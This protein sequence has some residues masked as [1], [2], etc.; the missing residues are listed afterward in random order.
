MRLS[1]LM[2]SPGA[3]DETQV[4]SVPQ[5]EVALRVHDVDDSQSGTNSEHVRHDDSKTKPRSGNKLNRPSS[6]RHFWEHLATNEEVLRR[7][8]THAEYGLTSEVAC[9]RLQKHG[10]N[11]LTLTHLEPWW[12]HVVRHLTDPLLILVQVGVLLCFSAFIV[13]RTNRTYLYM[14]LFVLSIIAFTTMLHLAHGQWA[15][16]EMRELRLRALRTGRSVVVRDGR[17]PTPI[18]ARDLVVGDV[19]LLREG[20]IVPADVRILQSHNFAVNNASLTG[21]SESITLASDTASV[22]DPLRATNLAFRGTTALQGACSAVVI[23]TGDRTLLATTAS[24]TLFSTDTKD[25][26]AQS[27]LKDNLRDFCINVCAVAVF[28]GITFFIVNLRLLRVNSK[29][30]ITSTVGIVTSNVPVGVL[31]TVT[32]SLMVSAQILRRRHKAVVKK[33]HSIATLGTITTM[34]IDKTG[35]LT[36]NDM[37]VSHL[38]FGGNVHVVDAKWQPPPVSTVNES[39][40]DPDVSGRSIESETM[41]N[42]ARA[43]FDA[44]LKAMSTCSTATISEDGSIIGGETSELAILHFTKRFHDTMKYRKSQKMVNMIPFDAYHRIMVTVTDESQI[45]DSDEKHGKRK[46]HVIMKGAAERV[47]DASDTVRTGKIVEGRDTRTM[48][49]SERHMWDNRVGYFGRRGER[50]LAYAECYIHDETEISRAIRQGDVRAIPT[51][52]GMTFLGLVSLSDAV[53]ED[54]SRAMSA[55]RA[56]GIRVWLTTGDGAATAMTTGR[57]AGVIAKET[58]VICEAHGD[59]VRHLG[60]DTAVVMEGQHL[61]SLDDEEW[62]RLLQN[63]EVIVARA[64]PADKMRTMGRLRVAGETMGA[65]GDG[66][67]DVGMVGLSDAG[68]ALGRSTN[69]ANC[70][71]TASVSDIYL[72]SDELVGIISGVTEG[73]RVWDNVKKGVIFSLSSNTSQMLVFMLAVFLQMPTPMSAGML[74]LC[75][76]WT[77]V[78]GCAA[79]AYEGP[80]PDVNSG[81]WSTREESSRLTCRS[82]SRSRGYSNRR[83]HMKKFIFNGRVMSFACLQ[84]GVMQCAAGL[85][86]YG[87]SFA[88]DGLSPRVL[89]GLDAKRGRFGAESRDAERWLAV[90]VRRKRDMRILESGG[91]SEAQGFARSVAWFSKSDRHFAQY[92]S[93]FPSSGFTW[94]EEETFDNLRPPGH[95]FED[96]VKVVGL[97]LQRPPCA[98]F[99]CRLTRNTGSTTNSS[100]SERAVVWNDPN[101]FT[102]ANPGGVKLHGVRTSRWQVRK[103]DLAMSTRMVRTD[104]C[105]NFWT[106]QRQREA[107][108]RAQVAAV[109]GLIIVR[110][111]SLWTCR[112]RI[113]SGFEGLSGENW[114]AMGIAMWAMISMVVGLGWSAART[115]DWWWWWWMWAIG[116]FFAVVLLVY[117]ELRKALVRRHLRNMT[118]MAVVKDCVL[119][120]SAKWTY[121]LTA[122]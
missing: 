36:Q 108:R 55:C 35:T 84:L 6:A 83:R 114:I 70:M 109:T 116:L 76:T 5:P 67:N 117:D 18:D 19:I 32:V 11:Q 17:A 58:Q 21:Q 95:L 103:H 115:R 62:D 104:E 38:S 50:V 47:L 90:V 112:R 1:A 119:N 87:I 44:L 16:Q 93:E 97:E 113:S 53:R 111:A 52:T 56:S 26:L 37:S 82:H 120:R 9:Y 96:M 98:V 2:S 12:K 54:A 106:P 23:A 71:A 118:E 8:G 60:N 99:S 85:F 105:I 121:S 88:R 31:V 30:S 91:R 39:E 48:S 86:G 42:D 20:D 49:V 102:D 27:P 101:C 57:T 34:L 89:A 24:M 46:L 94:D 77:E 51:M 78:F 66:G 4:N 14:S 110:M 107:L 64:S 28:V 69:E 15:T 13:D 74:L 22:A 81:N 25:A 7:L 80:E 68:V 33:L 63:D 41:V 73:R 61:R 100:S 75:G 59:V 45:V 92:F 43:C 65:V 40:V 29:N 122:W 72:D 10:M 79:L 3:K